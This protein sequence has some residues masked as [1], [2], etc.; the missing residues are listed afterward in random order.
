MLFYFLFLIQLLIIVSSQECNN[1]INIKYNN[2][3]TNVIFI[4]RKIDKKLYKIN[5]G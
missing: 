3:P 2:D 5:Y 1:F 4:K